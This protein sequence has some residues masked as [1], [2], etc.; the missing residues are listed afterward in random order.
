[1]PFSLYFFVSWKVLFAFFLYSSESDTIKQINIRMDLFQRFINWVETHEVKVHIAAGCVLRAQ[2]E[3]SEQANESEDTVHYTG[4]ETRDFPTY[5][6]PHFTN[7]LDYLFANSCFNHEVRQHR[8]RRPVVP[9]VIETCPVVTDTFPHFGV[10]VMDS[11]GGLFN[12]VTVKREADNGGRDNIARRSCLSM[13]DQ[14]MAYDLESSASFL[15]RGEECEEMKKRRSVNGR[16][17]L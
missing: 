1:M 14:T 9:T 2:G 12:R 7:Y 17:T 6:V 10:P 11:V 3:A 15:S 4:A 5:P 16:F 8:Q 13:S